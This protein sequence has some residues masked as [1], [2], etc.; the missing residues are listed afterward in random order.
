MNQPQWLEAISQR[1]SDFFPGVSCQTD[2][3]AGRIMLNA[4]GRHVSQLNVAELLGPAPDAEA[5]G[6]ILY[7]AL[8]TVQDDLL[9]FWGRWEAL[10]LAA[11]VE[12][13]KLAT[14]KVWHGS[15]RWHWGYRLPGGEVLELEPV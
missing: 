11:R 3:G 2:P 9:M 10:E 4:E 15:D 5:T 14:P 1:L 7:H 12:A 13:I 6:F 8:S